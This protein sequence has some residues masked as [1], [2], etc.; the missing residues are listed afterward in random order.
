MRILTTTVPLRGGEIVLLPVRTRG[1]VP[2]DRLWECLARANSLL[3]EAPV[4]VGQVVCPDLA[5]TGV[6]LIAT[7]TVAEIGKD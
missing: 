5:G 1:P 7:R 4:R 2:K 3:V 6:D